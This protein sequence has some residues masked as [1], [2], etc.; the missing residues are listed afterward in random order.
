MN[1][2]ISNDD[3][4]DEPMTTDPRK[5]E[6]EENLMATT[7]PRGLESNDDG[8][9]PG[10]SRQPA[11]EEACIDRNKE[12]IALHGANSMPG[13]FGRETIV[14]DSAPGQY[15]LDSSTKDTDPST[16]SNC[17]N[18]Y[19]SISTDQRKEETEE[20]LV[21]AAPYRVEN[22]YRGNNSSSA[23][24]LNEEGL[25]EDG[26]A[27][28]V[29]DGKPNFPLDKAF[30]GDNAA[31]GLSSR[32]DVAT[33]RVEFSGEGFDYSA[34]YELV[35][36]SNHIASHSQG[37][38]SVDS[39]FIPMTQQMPDFDYFSQVWQIQQLASVCDYFASFGYCSSHFTRLRLEHPEVLHI[40]SPR[41]RI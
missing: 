9:D 6:G 7:S 23:P 12:D 25:D 3:E 19:G 32:A 22:H 21:I 31:P 2:S 10:S 24:Q 8:G 36:Q 38:C 40:M 33:T 1:D 17:G 11:D 39:P 30:V 4:I 35:P 5:E 20:K 26:S 34:E 14:D 13:S 28:T 18:F 16:I 27:P 41:P 29:D 37:A 15:S